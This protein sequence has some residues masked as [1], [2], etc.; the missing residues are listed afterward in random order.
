MEELR[1]K[2]VQHQCPDEFEWRANGVFAVG[3]YLDKIK[4]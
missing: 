4:Y 2:I 1:V 3:E